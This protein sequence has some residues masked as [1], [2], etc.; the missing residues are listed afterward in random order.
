MKK[1]IFSILAL[2]SVIFIGLL[3][4]LC[5]R[6][7]GNIV[8]RYITEEHYRYSPVNLNGD[9]YF[10]SSYDFKDYKELK[11]IGH[12]S[13]KNKSF[14]GDILLDVGAVLVEDEDNNYMNFTVLDDNPMTYSN[15]EYLQ[16]S[17]LIENNM[18]KYK[19]FVLC[20][21]KD[22]SETRTAIQKELLNKLQEEFGIVKYNIEDFSNCDDI[23]Y[24]YVDLPKEKIHERTFDNPIIYIGCIFVDDGKFYYGN[25]K[26]EIKDQLLEQLKG[27]I[28][29]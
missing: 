24:I 29:S 21:D 15:I 2:G 18:D 1:V 11:I 20:N 5:V 19:D 27:Y 8:A 22:K 17:N 25:L 16:S 13:V 12:L 26:S 28:K 3:I 4:M 14:I 23:Y 7:Q 9:L 10:P 6:Q